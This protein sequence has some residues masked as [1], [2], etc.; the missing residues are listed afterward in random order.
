[1]G[2]SFWVQSPGPGGENA[3]AAVQVTRPLGMAR[4]FWR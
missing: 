4:V 1:M 2:D 3:G